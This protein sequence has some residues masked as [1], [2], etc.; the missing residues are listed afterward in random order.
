VAELHDLFMDDTPS[1]DNG[2]RAPTTR[3]SAENDIGMFTETYEE[4]E[5]DKS[6]AD[7]PEVPV[8]LTGEAAVTNAARDFP[9]LNLSK[10]EPVSIGAGQG[11]EPLQHRA[12]LA[13]DELSTDHQPPLLPETSSSILPFE[14]KLS[15]AEP[16]SQAAHAAS[17]SLSI[18]AASAST[19]Q[20]ASSDAL[21]AAGPSRLP[22]RS[23]IQARYPEGAYPNPL[24][25]AAPQMFGRANKWTEWSTRV[26]PGTL[27]D[28]MPEL[29]NI[30][31]GGEF[32]HV[33]R[34]QE[35]V[36]FRLFRLEIADSPA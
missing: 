34:D 3:A 23:D 14:P 16:S 12:V 9:D 21:P 10:E 7:I 19:E 15:H 5:S 8:L 33:M 1:P 28:L 13:D 11:D 6:A 18:S 30:Y 27:A 26:N 32:R 22:D 29:D 20:L 35:E 25:V 24:K 17:S 2:R 4:A 36:R 31:D